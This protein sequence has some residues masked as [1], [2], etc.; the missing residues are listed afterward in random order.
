MEISLEAARWLR[1]GALR[2]CP[3]LEKGVE[4]AW[5]FRAGKD[6]FPAE[7]GLVDR[8]ANGMKRAE[9]LCI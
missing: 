9:R 5:G 6:F 2:G 1:T 7:F 3:P 4:D 8:T